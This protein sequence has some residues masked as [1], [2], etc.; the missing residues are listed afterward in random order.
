MGFALKR[1]GAMV[2]AAMA[3]MASLGE[4]MKAAASLLTFQSLGSKQAVRRNL[5]GRPSKYMPHQGK[6]EIARRRTEGDVF[7]ISQHEWRA[8]IKRQAGPSFNRAP[9]RE[10]HRHALKREKKL[11]QSFYA[12][13]KRK[14]MVPA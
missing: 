5:A 8:D 2:A 7:G 13:M 11:R 3:A 12:L 1:H 4:S 10:A 14:G 9:I 6:R